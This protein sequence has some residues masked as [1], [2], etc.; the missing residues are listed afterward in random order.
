MTIEE[1]DF[2]LIQSN[3]T[4]TFFDL[5]LLS[6]INKGKSNE[7]QE[8]KTVGYGI[9]LERALHI[10]VMNRINSRYERSIDLKTFLKEFK[11]EVFK[12]KQ[13]CK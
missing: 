1:S 11:E 5:E 7:R 12:L 9:T 6:I 4:S 2:R 10:I 13:L 8:F 3:P